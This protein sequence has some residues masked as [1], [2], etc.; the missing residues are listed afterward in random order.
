MGIGDFLVPTS[1]QDGHRMNNG[2][3]ELE[4]K[5][6]LY[7]TDERLRLAQV[8]IE[9]RGRG[10]SNLLDGYDEKQSSRWTNFS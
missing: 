7:D 1:K 4:T 10:G 5:E 8:A 9:Y 6:W 2:K 3:S